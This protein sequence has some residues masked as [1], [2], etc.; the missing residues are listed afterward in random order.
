MKGKRMIA[1]LLVTVTTLAVP[2]DF[3]AKGREFE[4]HIKHVP[5]IPF[6][7][8]GVIS[9]PLPN[10]RGFRIPPRWRPVKMLDDTHVYLVKDAYRFLVPNHGDQS[11]STYL[12]WTQENGAMPE[13]ILWQCGDKEA[14][15]ARLAELD[16]KEAERQR[17]IEERRAE[18]EKNRQR[19]EQE[20]QQKRE[21]RQQQRTRRHATPSRRYAAASVHHKR[22]MGMQRPLADAVTE[23][24]MQIL[25]VK[26]D[27]ENQV[28][29]FNAVDPKAVEDI[30]RNVVA[31]MAIQLQMRDLEWC[32][33]I[34]KYLAPRMW[35]KIG[36]DTLQDSSPEKVIQWLVREIERQTE[37]AESM[38]DVIE[39]D[40][41]HE[42]EMGMRKP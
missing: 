30:Q 7:Q 34:E 31:V 23:R 19:R 41:L 27:K 12:L 15:K 13:V 1:A 11:H 4:E 2:P 37:N 40:K 6:T 16:A 25:T 20:R 24:V 33:A 22:L 32:D 29:T 3:S 36:Q 21:L 18:A 39:N 17:K 35:E 42:I 14:R 9:T 5:R 28:T 26:E 8:V 10:V 38:I